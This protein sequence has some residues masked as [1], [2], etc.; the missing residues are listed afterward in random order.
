MVT[1]KLENVRKV[2]LENFKNKKVALV[3]SGGVTKA[4]AWHMGVA[5][6]LTEL[7]FTLKHNESK[8]SDLEISTYVGSSAGA[9]MSLYFAA[10]YSP[11][12][13]INANLNKDNRIIRPVE[14][15]DML[16]IRR[17]SFAQKR[18]TDYEPF[19]N[20]PF[21][22]KKVLSPLRSFNGLFS[23]N[24]LHEYTNREILKGH[25]S[26][27]DFKADLFVVATQLDHS[28]KVIFSK[29]KY[30]SPYHDPTAVYYQGIDIADSVAA[31]M[32]VPPFYSPTPVR[33]P[34]TNQ[35]DYYIDGEIRETLS[36][37]VAVDNKCDFVISSWT[38]TPYH[39]QEEIGS[40]INYGLPAICTQA[41]YLLIQ[42]KIVD[43][44]SRRAAA[45]DILSTVN[46]YL[47]AN[48]FS[49]DDTKKLTGIL[50]RKLN[51]NPNI[52]FVDI[53]PKHDNF[54]FFFK[55]PFSLNPQKMRELVRLGHQRT[56]EVFKN[57]ESES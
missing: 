57:Q 24:G 46:E 7:G 26:F 18:K 36:T 56:I 41:I 29:Y 23:T 22:I 55:N 38:H 53:F 17:K 34:Y 44:R 4:A 15:G 9:L 33:N 49:S 10:G 19:A 54:N 50:E 28:R 6:A 21:I 52:H 14:Y 30:P 3:L 51:F 8:A 42:K 47:K 11:S 20:F 43:S 37:H 35:T 2:A 1:T 39:Y 31:S 40:L 25:S 45:Q 48:K 16:S 5:R 12:D 13:V 27:D 32:S